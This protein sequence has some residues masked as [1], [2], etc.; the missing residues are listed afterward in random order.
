MKK[1][2]INL[3]IILTTI[4]TT[5]LIA[6]LLV[7]FLR[8]KIHKYEAF[9][10]PPSKIAFCFLTYG[11][12]KHPEIWKKFFNNNSDKYSLYLHPKYLSKVSDPFFKKRI[13]KNRIPTQWGDVSL[14]KATLNLFSEAYKDTRN[15]KFVLLSDSCL[16]L[17]N[18]EYI[19]QKLIGNSNNLTYIH[20]LGWE[21]EAMKYDRYQKL[22][23]KEQIRL[24]HF[25]KQSQWM[26]LD[27]NDYNFLIKNG[28]LDDYQKMFAPDEQYFINLFDQYHRK[29]KNQVTTYVNWD[30]QSQSPK[31]YAIL[32]IET[33]TRARQRG[34]FFIRKIKKEAQISLEYLFEDK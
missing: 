4:L 34:A 21:T 17:Y 25:R 7:A 16:P 14:V 31:E 1:E 6:L 10:T 19:Y 26:I 2:I 29:Y 8:K 23:N 11:Q 32:D 18:F 24:K 13:I 20:H 3:T 30:N 9:Q 5:I 28:N 33:I 12:P 22:E 15:K 27:R